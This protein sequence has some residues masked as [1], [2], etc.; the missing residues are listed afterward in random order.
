VLSETFVVNEAAALA[1]AGHRVS[2]EARQRPQN[3]AEAPPV[4]VPHY[5]AYEERRGERLRALAWLATRHPVR[6]AADVVSR[7]ARGKSDRGTKTRV[8]AVRARR[9]SRLGPVH[10]HTHFAATIADDAYRVARL[11]SV[12]SSVTAHAWDIYTTPERL[13]ERL[14]RSDFVTS[15]C[16]YTVA[17]L[18][19]VVGPAHEEKVFKQIM[20]IDTES[21]R[22]TG[23][24]PGTRHVIGVGRLVEKKGFIHL[25]RA[26]AEL[27]EVTISIVGEGPERQTLESEIDRHDLAGRV[28]LLGA[29]DP[30]QV[31][32]LLER[33]DV[34]CMPCVVAGDGDRDSMPVV[35]KEAMAMELM[36][37]ASDEVG[38]PEIVR[39]PWG[40]LVPPGEHA[41]L[42]TAVAEALA[43]DPSAR[44]A[45]GKA[46]REFVVEHANIERETGKLSE[47]IERCRVE[48]RR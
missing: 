29:A 27:P 22:R 14:V 6:T 19:R 41:P 23:P 43:L 17:D 40:R 45:A 30:D 25:V 46:G 31:R 38:L 12:P 7:L 4:D 35:V 42:A 16:E 3:Q 2:V 47:W 36:V 24:L 1:R 28:R 9:L 5:Y 48:R 11:L 13:R 8:L 34:L 10:V 21:F 26:A 20:G 18:K 32:A 15:G 44:A 39:P 33:A 37:V